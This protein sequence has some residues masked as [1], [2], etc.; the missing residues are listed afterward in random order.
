MF[1]SYIPYFITFT[2]LLLKLSYLIMLIP[3][4]VIIKVNVYGP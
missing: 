2:R 4:S 3:M 1:P